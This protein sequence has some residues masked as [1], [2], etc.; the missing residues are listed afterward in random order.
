MRMPAGD[1]GA[2]MTAVIATSRVARQTSRWVRFAAVTV[3]VVPALADEVMVAPGV[4]RDEAQRQEAVC[5][6]HEA[7]RHALLD[8]CG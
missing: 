5:G 3:Q 6:A 7:L 4:L 1:L 8:E 2:M